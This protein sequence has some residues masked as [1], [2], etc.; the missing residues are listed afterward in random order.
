MVYSATVLQP[1]NPTDLFTQ[2]SQLA[3]QAD[4]LLQVLEQLSNRLYRP[5]TDYTGPNS[6]PEILPLSERS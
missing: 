2:F 3:E 1:R 5:L 6:Q 4:G